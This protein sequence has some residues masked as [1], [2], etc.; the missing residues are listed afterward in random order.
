MTIQAA[1][2]ESMVQ[3]KV[4]P[5]AKFKI[6]LKSREVQRRYPNLLE[7]FLDFGK[8]GGLDIEQKASRFYDLVKSKKSAEVE[9]LIGL[10][11]PKKKE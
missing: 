8:F 3:L 4:T 5:Y 6:A 7:R 2:T 10:C 11:Y 9:D 1:T